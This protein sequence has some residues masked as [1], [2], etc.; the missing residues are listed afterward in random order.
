MKTA[1]EENQSA[2]TN[3]EINADNSRPLSGDIFDGQEKSLD[4]GA[5]P[6]KKSGKGF[7]L[8]GLIALLSSVILLAVCI[9]VFRSLT[10]IQTNPESTG[11]LATVET[12]ALT[13]E[14]TSMATPVP[15]STPTPEPTSTPTPEPTNTLTP[16]PTSTPTPTPIPEPTKTPKQLHDEQMVDAWVK[17]SEK[18]CNTKLVSR[19][20][21]IDYTE[22]TL[23][24]I[25]KKFENYTGAF[26]S[27]ENSEDRQSVR[28]SYDHYPEEYA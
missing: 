9:R 12:D 7:F 23:S 19:D 10:D 22:D 21:K 8:A 1:S 5:K 18:L 25:K 27:E 28:I 20:G 16:E 6:E 17:V 14:P 3:S 4:R 24:E 2:Q 13:P 26:V 11:T 15:T